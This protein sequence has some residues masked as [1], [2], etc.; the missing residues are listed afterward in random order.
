[1]CVVAEMGILSVLAK[2]TITNINTLSII[3][4]SDIVSPGFT[5]SG[6][7]TFTNLISRG[8]GLSGYLLLAFWAYTQLEYSCPE[9]RA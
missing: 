9:E 3:P 6:V 8:V 4:V 7:V 1:M 5:P 2:R